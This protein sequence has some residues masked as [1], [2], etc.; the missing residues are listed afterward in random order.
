MLNTVKHA[1]TLVYITGAYTHGP[2]K[3]HR[4]SAKYITVFHY[5]YLS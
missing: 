1:K 4:P 5:S 2:L 3:A